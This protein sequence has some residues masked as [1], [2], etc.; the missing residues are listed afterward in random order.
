MRQ[1]RAIHP[2]ITKT[3][4]YTKYTMAAIFIMLCFSAAQRAL[5]FWM[6]G[7]EEGAKNQREF[8]PSPG[9]QER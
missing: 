2:H 7:G 8:G 6:G 4:I 3:T 9:F 5:A 1:R